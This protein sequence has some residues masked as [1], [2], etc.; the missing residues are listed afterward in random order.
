MS[1]VHTLNDFD[2]FWTMVQGVEIDVMHIVIRDTYVEE[3]HRAFAQI[4]IDVKVL[5]GQ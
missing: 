4:S 5:I 3:D 2:F 1:C